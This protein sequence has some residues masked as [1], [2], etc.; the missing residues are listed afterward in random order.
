MGRLP[1]RELNMNPTGLEPRGEAPRTAK[2]SLP[3]WLGVSLEWLLALVILFEE[4]GWEPL[5]R[6]M[7]RLARWS[8]IAAVERRLAALPP[9]GAL[10]AFALPVLLLLPV[11]LFALWLTALGRA[12]LGTAL[13][14]AAKLVGT[15][16]VARIFTLTHPALMQLAWFARFYGRWQA[17][18][19]VLIAMVRAS[20][21]W[22]TIRSVRHRFAEWRRRLRARLHGAWLT[23]RQI[24]RRSA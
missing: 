5:Q 13:I 23:L 24:V 11:N 12:A 6:F 3:R 4:W 22:Q 21:V 8:V 2:R 16:L 1:G 14:I 7:E 20:W 15:T 18:K 10:L 9:A 19:A 17:F